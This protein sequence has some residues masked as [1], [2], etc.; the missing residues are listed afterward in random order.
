M[1]WD[2]YAIEQRRRNI[3]WICKRWPNQP[4]RIAQMMRI[5]NCTRY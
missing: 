1:D 4:L 5:L 2:A 3:E